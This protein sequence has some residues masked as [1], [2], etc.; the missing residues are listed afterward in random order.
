MNCLIVDDEVLARDILAIYIQKTPSLHLKGMCRSAVEAFEMLNTTDVDLV[1]LD[2]KMPEISR[3]DFLKK[4]KNPPLVI[5]TTAFPE[6]ALDGYDLNIVDYLMKPIRYERF[7][8]AIDKASIMLMNTA[9][10]IKHNKQDVLFVK[11]DRKLVRIKVDDLL[12]I[13]GLRNYLAIQTCDSRKIIVHSS[14]VAMEQQ[15]TTY[16]NIQRVHKSFMINTQFLLEVENH[17]VKMTDGAQIPV[18]NNYR[19]EFYSFLK[20]G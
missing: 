16:S 7:V 18:G 13:E 8:K 4:L 15:L 17:I 12:Y 14:F 2:I 6:F 1:L 20:L 5:I 19:K 10:G 9:P 11:S 3:I